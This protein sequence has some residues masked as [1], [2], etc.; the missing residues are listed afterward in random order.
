MLYCGLTRKAPLFLLG[1]KSDLKVIDPNQA[2]IPFVTTEEAKKAARQIG[3]IDAL[4]CSAMDSDSIK[5]IGDLLAWHG[6]YSH[7]R[8][9]EMHSKDAK[10]ISKSRS[11]LQTLLRNRRNK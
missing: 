5:R 9:N 4:E 2:S 6:Y 11:R 1:C 10:G 8:K 3:A 7:F